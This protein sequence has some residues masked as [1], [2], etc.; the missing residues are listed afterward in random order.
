MAD[1]G[2]PDEAQVKKAQKPDAGR[3]DTSPEDE[4]IARVKEILDGI[5]NPN[6]SLP[7]SKVI[8]LPENAQSPSEERKM[9]PVQE[10]RPPSE[11]EARPIIIEQGRRS[12]GLPQPVPPRRPDVQVDR[13][14]IEDERGLRAAP[15]R[16]ERLA[17]ERVQRP[18]AQRPERTPEEF[19]KERSQATRPPR[20][21][22]RIERG[23]PRL[24]RVDPR[25]ERMEPRVERVEPR[26]EPRPRPEPEPSRR[27]PPTFASEIPRH[28]FAR[29]EREVMAESKKN[30]APAVPGVASVNL[31]KCPQCGGFVNPT[32][33]PT[34]YNCGYTIT[35]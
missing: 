25:L 15:P 14:L 6:I 19:L 9:P 23:E 13:D 29:E 21:E 33:S 7:P 16:P 27:S 10:Q 35:L 17:E 28:S 24:E 26:M 31:F 34:C 20:T 12:D 3:Y 2:K 8:L 11:Q 18:I 4:T 22:P 1:A 30:Y 5:A 32:V